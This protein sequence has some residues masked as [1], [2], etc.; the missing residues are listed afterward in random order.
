MVTN[1][2]KNEDIHPLH[3]NMNNWISSGINRYAL[4][5]LLDEWESLNIK[6]IKISEVRN[7]VFSLLANVKN[8]PLNKW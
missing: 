1:I 4:Y 2:I 8:Y 6:S 7:E 3:M 5:T